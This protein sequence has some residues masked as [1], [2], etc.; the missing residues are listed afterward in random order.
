MKMP[1]YIREKF[2][3][4]T[5]IRATMESEF[6]ELA[7]KDDRIVAL[8]ADSLPWELSPEALQW[9]R[10]NAPERYIDVGIAE[11]HMVTVAGGLAKEGLTVF[12]FDMAWLFFR[13]YN[14][15]RQ[16]IGIDRYN[17]KLIGNI[18]WSASDG[19]SHQTFEDIALMRTIPNMIVCAPAD[20]VETKKMMRATAQYIGPVYWRHFRH[21]EYVLPFPIIFEEDYPFK[22]GVA[23][24]VREGDDATIIGI[25]E[26]I[27]KGFMAAERLAKEG[28]AARIINMSTIKPID[29]G[30]IIKAAN[31]T[32][33][34]V[35]AE[36]ASIIGGLGSAVAEVVVENCPV[37]MK[38][39]GIRDRYGQS[40]TDFDKM[41]ADYSLTVDSLVNAVKEV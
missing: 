12:G 28:I 38:R 35:T 27:P 37:P 20:S 10:Q 18:L 31:E 19:V 8:G 25:N 21:W 34:I 11:D 41:D 15:I 30:A 14:Q 7:K 2:G 33:A 26:W 16:S 23:T 13:G 40:T 36:T 1:K 3:E 9:F 4:P 29:K 32:G 24:T 17:V 5:D 22:F 6:L 39:I